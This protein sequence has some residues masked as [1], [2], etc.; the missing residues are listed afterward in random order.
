MQ[1]S[2]FCPNCGAARL[3]G[4]RFCGSCGFDF[5]GG[6]EPVTAAP[7]AVPPAPLQPV[8]PTGVAS[9][10]AG[11]T[12]VVRRHWFTSTPALVVAA[13]LVAAV[14]GIALSKAYGQAAPGTVGLASTFD[15]GTRTTQPGSGTTPTVGPTT[16][17]PVDVGTYTAQLGEAVTITSDG[18]NWA[19]VTVSKVSTHSCY[20]C[21]SFLPD[22]PKKGYVYLQA[23]VTYKA[24][25]NNVDYNPFDW[26]V[27]VN[28]VAADDYTF[29]SN[30]P[31]PALSSGTLP[32]G[33]SAKGWLVYE[34]PK[35]G[36]VV[37]SYGS[38]RFSDQP[39][40]FEVVLRCH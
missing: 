30:G 1:S 33:R 31:D 6:V 3:G 9:V 27:F 38:N 29:V 35:T 39:P 15:P 18:D 20:G 11:D 36:R 32:K 14:A 22:K 5:A 7:S 2:Q 13:V 28:D 40:V 4:L 37:L 16:P 19:S 24:L 23:W 8:P 17:P 21:S 34:V 26:S 25:A 10:P 12:D